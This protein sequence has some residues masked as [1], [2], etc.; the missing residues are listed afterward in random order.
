ME[1]LLHKRNV[2]TQC[3]DKCDDHISV[4]NN[5]RIIN[6]RHKIKHGTIT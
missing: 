1:H 2:Y 4:S 5:G 3:Y 6:T